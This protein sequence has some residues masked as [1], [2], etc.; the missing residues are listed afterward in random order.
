M[1]GRT[2]T[3]WGAAANSRHLV[4][5]LKDYRAERSGVEISARLRDESQLEGRQVRWL[6][7]FIILPRAGYYKCETGFRLRDFSIEDEE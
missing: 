4:L 3:F 6:V 1:Q 7:Y 5:Y 2:I